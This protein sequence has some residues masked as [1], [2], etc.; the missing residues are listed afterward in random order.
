MFFQLVF[1]L[2]RSKELIIKLLKTIVSEIA[3]SIDVIVR[4]TI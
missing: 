3:I 1:T 4:K 2:A